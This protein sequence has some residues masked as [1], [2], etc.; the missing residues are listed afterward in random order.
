MASDLPAL[1]PARHL[2]Q[3]PD[4]RRQGRRRDGRYRGVPQRRGRA[5]R[6]LFSV[7][8]IHRHRYA[9]LLRPDTVLIGLHPS[10]TQIDPARRD[11]RIPGSRARRRPMIEAPKGGTQHHDRHRPLHER[12]Q[13]ARGGG[14]WMAGAESM[15]N[16]V[17]FLGGHGTSTHRWQPRESVQ[18]H[19]H[20]RPGPQSPL[21]RAVSEPLGDRWRR[22]NASSISGRRARSHS[23]GC[24][25]RDTSTEG[26]VYQMSSEH[27]VRNEVQ[28]RNARQLAD[29]CAADRGGARRGRFAL[30]LEIDNSQQHH[31]RELS[32]LPRD[33]HLSAV[34]VCDEGRE[35]EE[36]P[37]PQ[38]SLLQQ[39][40]G[41]VR[42][43]DLRPDAQC[44][45][46]AARVRV[47]DAFGR[48]AGRAVESASAVLAAGAK[49]EKL[50]GGFYNISGGA[51]GS[52]GRLLFC[53]RALAA[54]LPLVGGGAAAFDGPRRTARSGESGF[55]QGRQPDGGVVR[56]RGNGVLVAAGVGGRARSRCC[57]PRTRRR[58]RA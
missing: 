46:P 38:H 9:S 34:S 41:L 40:Q 30:P 51:V 35:L 15:M 27:H 23:R 52:G 19:A 37:L 36:H 13:S 11:A 32:H 29:L 57:R 5:S 25:C 42:Q 24:S 1:P 2:G 50:A 53:G 54:H 58:G 10:A 31:G 33:Q 56:G 20:G 17:R 28:L 49:V 8:Q 22:R 48:R 43:R 16:D 7:R 21:G 44:G 47:A 45:S 26:R 4:A 12:R 6:H 39:Q 18:Q 55:R 3:R 14:K